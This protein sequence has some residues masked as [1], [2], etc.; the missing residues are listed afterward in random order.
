MRKIALLLT[1]SLLTACIDETKRSKESQFYHVLVNKEW[2]VTTKKFM[3][4]IFADSTIKF[5]R[6][7]TMIDT[8]VK[9]MKNSKVSYEFEVL[10]FGA[11]GLLRY[12]LELKNCM[13]VDNLGV[14]HITQGEWW[15][16]SNKLYINV[17]GTENPDYVFHYKIEYEI[18]E[19][20]TNR[21]R[22]KKVKDIISDSKQEKQF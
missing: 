13:L 11:N 5:T 16:D 3:W 21:L 19:I 20:D 8:A 1:L 18:S 4:P 22:L 6:R 12:T 10:S 14:M 7:E 17:K 15:L 9:Q 2:V